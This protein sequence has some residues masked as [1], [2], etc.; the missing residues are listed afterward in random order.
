[1]RKFSS[2]DKGFTF[3]IIKDNSFGKQIYDLQAVKFLFKDAIL[4]FYES[5]LYI[6]YDKED[7]LYKTQSQLVSLLS[8]LRD[9][10]S[11][12]LAV[13]ADN[14]SD[15]F[16]VYNQKVFRCAVNANHTIFF[17]HYRLFLDKQ[18]I[19]DR[20]DN[21]VCSKCKQV[22][23]TIEG[24]LVRYFVSRIYATDTLKNLVGNKFKYL[25]ER[26]LDLAKVSIV[27]SI[28]FSFL[29][30]VWSVFMTLYNNEHAVTEIKKEQFDPILTNSNKSV[31]SLDSIFRKIEDLCIINHSLHVEISFLHEDNKQLQRTL[32]VM[33]GIIN[34][35]KKQE[36]KSQTK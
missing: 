5:R 9:L 29:S 31:T 12:S 33:Q 28:A 4:L 36:I 21:L 26:S 34:G 24:L 13:F 25:E 27:F 14:Q 8:L 35:L 6:F 19:L 22:E 7:N 2:F 1:M 17:D 15:N 16:V 23:G 11:E 32:S 18:K 30:L 20:L 3:E 10:E